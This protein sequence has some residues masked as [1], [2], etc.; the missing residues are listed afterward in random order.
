MMVNNITHLGYGLG[1]YVIAEFVE[2][3]ETLQLLRE[4]G[5]HFAQGFHIQKPASIEDWKKENLQEFL[6]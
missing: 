3:E 5:V 4:I 6:V 1:L 2:D